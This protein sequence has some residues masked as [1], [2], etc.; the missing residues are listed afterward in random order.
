MTA[1]SRIITRLEPGGPS[2]LGEVL[3]ARVYDPLWLLARQWQVGEWYGEDAGT[4]IDAQLSC[5]VTTLT[6]LGE[7]A[8]RLGP[9]DPTKPLESQV[10]APQPG[11]LPLW[12]RADGGRLLAEVAEGV[13]GLL[14]A[15]RADHPLAPPDEDDTDALPL[16]ELW[17][18]AL[19]DGESLLEAL[20]DL[21][22]PATPL[23]GTLPEAGRA[24]LRA[25]RD[26]WSATLPAK[27]VVDAWQ[28]TGLTHRFAVAAASDAGLAT[29]DAEHPGG[30]LD[31]YR[32]TA[33]GT[34]PALP[35]AG[36][37]ERRTVR[38]IPA[39]VRF[40]GMPTERWWQVDDAVVDL[41]AVDAGSADLARLLVLD[42]AISYGGDSYLIPLRLPSA[43]WT[44]VDGLSVTDSFG[45][46]VS[47][48]PA[49][50]ADWAM[51]TVGPT[52]G[53]LM[54][55]GAVGRTAGDATEELSLARDELANLA[56]LVE[57]RWEGGLGD[58]IDR[59]TAFGTPSVLVPA[60]DADL[61]WRL[62]DDPPPSWVPM[63]PSYDAALGPVLARLTLEG[64]PARSALAGGI[65]ANLPDRAVPR[66]GRRL[67]RQTHLA[68][69]TD[70]TPITWV[71]RDTGVT[72]P[73]TGAA[74]MRYDRADPRPQASPDP[75]NAY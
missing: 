5:T 11:K 64:R 49:A 52:N 45:D 25:W 1:R 42:F 16:Y 24:A 72:R 19:P 75:D 65:S 57:E 15:A 3:A 54:V 13:D 61:A 26:R 63:L 46:T 43:S 41:G 59:P 33:T 68:H 55:P 44:T 28:P 37:P 48:S 4:A 60:H 47:L 34:G 71:A 69:A 20:T 14:E 30:E 7:T 2:P 38:L 8:Q 31:W 36:P 53:L 29:F 35:G 12:R 70:G 51:F 58:P 56:W 23:P 74:G 32:F 73:G 9:L 6:H 67:R 62:V 18:K 27:P 21:D 50:A 22:D 10:E 40:P 66:S 39:T 17:R